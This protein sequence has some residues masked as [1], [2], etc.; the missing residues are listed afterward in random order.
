[1]S[2]Y[3]TISV[4]QE[5]EA[6]KRK[7]LAE[8]LVLLTERQRAMFYRLWSPELAQRSLAPFEAEEP[9]KRIDVYAESRRAEWWCWVLIAVAVVALL[10][11]GFEFVRLLY[12]AI[13]QR[14]NA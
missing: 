3:V 10:A 12:D 9:M 14:L 13:T 2:E 1:M 11:A 4:Q 8:R 5:V 7:L 6:F